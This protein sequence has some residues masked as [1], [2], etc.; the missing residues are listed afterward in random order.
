[1]SSSDPR[2]NPAPA[3]PADPPSSAANPASPEVAPP[4]SP[5]RG[6]PDM[7]T[8]L[9]LPTGA[10]GLRAFAKINLHL[11]VLRLRPDG[12]HS[13]ETVFQSVGLFDTLHLV[14]RP[15]GISM[16]CDSKHL[17][18]DEDNLCLRAARALLE[19]AG[20]EEPPVGVR[21]DLYK[22]IPVAAGFAGGSADAA[23]T[24]MGLNRLWKL[25]FDAERLAAVGARLGSD[26]VFCLRGGTAF[27]TGRG[28]H[29]ETL[30]DLPETIFLLVYPKIAI[31]AEWAYQQLNMGLTRRPRT[32]SMNRLKTI[33]ARYQSAARVFYNRLEDA[34]VPTHPRVAEVTDQLIECGATY[35]MM[36]GSGSGVF[37]V[38]P[39][40]AT[41]EAARG[42]I[43]RLD[44]PRRVV[45]SR[46]KGVE[47]FGP[48]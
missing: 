24:L 12:W 29:L 39:D 43:G 28:D 36:S 16:L 5:T 44:W 25:K 22:R 19:E 34:V 38:F 46:T 23:A 1:M 21:I 31:S 4:M 8:P 37:G 27:G 41:A 20:L 45:T 32:L 9:A 30:T 42:E 47:F 2:R 11:E 35:A 13:I 48:V 6:R 18:V 26:V 14:P 15:A 33:L 17:S 40:R 7:D 3:S 10:I